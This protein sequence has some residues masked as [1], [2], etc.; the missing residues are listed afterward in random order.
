MITRRNYLIGISAALVSAPAIVRVNSLMR[1]RGIVLPIQPKSYYGFCDRLAIKYRYVNGE[2]RGSALIRM[3]DEGL[4]QHVP[5]AILAYDL[6]KW[7]TA[8][9]SSAAREERRAA[10]WPRAKV[11]GKTDCMH[12]T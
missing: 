7:G 2:L 12:T 5:P 1:V 9:L 3:I 8:E 4:L 10:L 6:A 11:L